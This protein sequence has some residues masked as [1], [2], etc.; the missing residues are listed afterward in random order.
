MAR[1][2]APGIAH[3]VT[4]RGNARQTVFEDPEDRRVYLK[5]LRGHAMKQRLDIWAWCLMTNHIHL[6]VVPGTG[7]GLAKA[8]GSTHRD[9]ARYRNTRSGRS[10][11]LWQ[12]R[13][14]S[15]P[16]DDRGIFPVM[17]YIER[18]PVRAGVVGRAEDY[19]WSSAASH[20]GG[21]DDR[22]FI[23][24]RAWREHYT[25]E[26]WREALRI[27]LD[28][29]ALRERI[30]LATR[31]GRPLGSDGFTGALECAEG[32]RLRVGQPGRPRKSLVDD[33][34][35]VLAF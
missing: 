12:A 14:Y 5:L 30:R 2:V 15:C 33:R 11:H 24:L 23:D 22:G 19:L 17:A 28:D 1:V 35:V 8:L 3:H 26:R 9:Y 13:Y 7:E 31:T 18:N 6:L 10:G 32:R 21:T 20:V 16:V 27:G 29:E 4:Q 34:Q 25:G